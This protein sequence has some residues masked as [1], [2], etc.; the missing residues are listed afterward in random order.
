MTEIAGRDG[1]VQLGRRARRSC[2][3][4]FAS[5]GTRRLAI[6]PVDGVAAAASAG[7]GRCGRIEP[8]LVRGGRRHRLPARRRTPRRRGCRRRR[9]TRAAR[10]PQPGCSTPPRAADPNAIAA[11]GPEEASSPTRTI[12]IG[13]AFTVEDC[14]AVAAAVRKVAA[15]PA[16]GEG[17]LTCAPDSR[18]VITPELPVYLAGYGD[19]RD[20][21]ST[22]AGPTSNSASSSSRTVTC[23]LA[24]VTCGPSSR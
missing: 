6:G 19:R 5:I 24:L 4:R 21:A 9:C 10:V 7:P 2:S 15:R 3:R 22:A 14:D 8:H 17:G 1:H 16:V 11:R 20:P 12:G 13:P 23:V 18:V